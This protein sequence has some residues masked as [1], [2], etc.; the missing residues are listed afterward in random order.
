MFKISIHLRRSWTEKLNR[1]RNDRKLNFTPQWQK[2]NFLPPWSNLNTLHQNP[3]IL[4]I[5][6]FGHDV[7]LTPA[8]FPVWGFI[9][10][11]VIFISFARERKTALNDY[12]TELKRLE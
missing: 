7:I 4:K 8:P 6:S 1:R 10:T 12:A 5:I 3:Q 11:M 2:L 9:M